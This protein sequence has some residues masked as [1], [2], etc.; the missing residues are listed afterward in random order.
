SS[1][2]ELR[3]AQAMTAAHTRNCALAV[4]IDTGDP[5]NIHPMDKQ[6]V[7][8]RLA[9]CALNQHYG[10]NIPYQGPIYVSLQHLPGA[11]KLKFAHTNGGLVARGGV[12]EEFSVAGAD[13]KWHWAQAKI[14]GG[15]VIV[16]SPDV[17]DP[18]AARYAWQSFPKATLYNGASLPA[19]PFRTDNWPGI[20]ANAK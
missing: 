7:G 4:T 19:V 2:A 5:D 11:L 15:A 16:S 8:V 13:R 17:P 12:P 20:T 3:E 9:Y 6:I 10:E 18:V 14:D 1:W